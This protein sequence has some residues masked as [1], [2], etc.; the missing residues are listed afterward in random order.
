MRQVNDGVIDVL[1]TDWVA[2]FTIHP[3]SS[4]VY[5]VQED[6]GGITEDPELFYSESEAIARF[7]DLVNGYYKTQF[8]S[9][10]FDSAQNHAQEEWD[11]W[12]VRLFSRAEIR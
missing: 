2:S 7:V 1:A 12:G 11:E 8:A 3:E 5:V 6:N 4:L 9:D 10:D